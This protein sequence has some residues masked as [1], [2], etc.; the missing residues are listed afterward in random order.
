MNA[1]TQI[2]FKEPKPVKENFIN[3]PCRNLE[4]LKQESSPFFLNQAGIHSTIG[5]TS[6]LNMDMHSI[7]NIHIIANNS[8]S[9]KNSSE[10]N[11]AIRNARL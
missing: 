2:K 4:I 6:F 9:S 8:M 10:N 1:D 5:N 11:D 3:I 7:E